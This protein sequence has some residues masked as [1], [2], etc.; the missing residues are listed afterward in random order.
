M[1]ISEFDEA[2]YYCNVPFT[3]QDISLSNIL[4]ATSI[5]VALQFPLDSAECIKGALGFYN[6]DNIEPI[7]PIVEFNKQ[8]I[9]STFQ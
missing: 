7:N 5:Q 1:I 6:N 3:N 9:Y 2:Q 4:F 8:N